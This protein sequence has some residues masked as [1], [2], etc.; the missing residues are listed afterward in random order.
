MWIISL[1]RVWEPVRRVDGA[2]ERRPSE[3]VIEVAS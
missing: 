3:A 1:G 2:D